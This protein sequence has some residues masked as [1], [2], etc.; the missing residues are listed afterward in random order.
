MKLTR[1]LHD[2]PQRI[3]GQL[4]ELGS[5]EANFLCAIKTDFKPNATIPTLWLV[6]MRDRLVLCNTHKTRGYWAGY[7]TKDL[8]CVKLSRGFTGGIQVEIIHNDNERPDRSLPLSRNTSVEDA[9]ELM[10]LVSMLVHG[11][12]FS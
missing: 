8:N 4:R 3:Q 2:L 12:R 11:K 7:S 9:R 6:V 5:E 10:A 1:S